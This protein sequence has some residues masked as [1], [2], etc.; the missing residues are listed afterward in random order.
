[1]AP[2]AVLSSGLSE[3]IE[4]SII[5]IRSHKVMFDA[6]LAVLYGV[7][8]EQLNAQVSATDQTFQMTFYFS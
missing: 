8:T 4:R 3:R 1:M 2:A 6:G 5:S 7:V